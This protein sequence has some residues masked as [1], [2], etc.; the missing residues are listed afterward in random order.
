MLNIGPIITTPQFFPCTQ[1]LTKLLLTPLLQLDIDQPF[2]KQS[3][4]NRAYILGA[5]KVLR[6][7][8]PLQHGKTQL[9]LKDV[10]I[11]YTVPWVRKAWTAIASAYGKTPFF[12]FYGGEVEALLNQRHKFLVDLNM[13]SIHLLAN[14]FQLPFEYQWIS[15]KDRNWAPEADWRSRIH[16]KV[17]WEQD[18]YFH[19]YPY[20]QAFE[21]RFGFTA[22]L[23][24]LDLLFN[25]GPE[26]KQILKAAIPY[27]SV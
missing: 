5:N 13:A 2:Q 4:Q 15:L 6:L 8:I 11:D 3:Y 23:S 24:G 22:N 16:P 1:W 20:R 21:E 10:K 12:P 7:S 9:P 27:S 17:D 18:P 26:G 19:P 14:A 25:E